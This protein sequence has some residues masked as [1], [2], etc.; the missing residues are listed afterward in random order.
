M[1]FP[2]PIPDSVR[3]DLPPGTGVLLGISGGGDSAVT[4]AGNFTA[5]AMSRMNLDKMPGLDLANTRI[6]MQL[7]AA[8]AHPRSMELLVD[9]E[10]FFTMSYTG[11][12]FLES[13]DLE[14]DA[15]DYTPPE[16]VPVTDL[17]AQLEQKPAEITPQ[18]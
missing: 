6:R 11:I 5:E 15:F 13:A 12:E 8:K 4:L 7:D 10:P 2:L 16:G 1:T 9:G 14:K 3:R 17:D 18:G